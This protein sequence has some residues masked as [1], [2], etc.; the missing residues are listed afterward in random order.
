ML[1][2]ILDIIALSIPAIKSGGRLIGQ[3]VDFSCAPPYYSRTRLVSRIYIQWWLDLIK[4]E[5]NPS[6]HSETFLAP[7]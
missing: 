5:G 3:K 2:A 1:R 7:A 6:E 4:E